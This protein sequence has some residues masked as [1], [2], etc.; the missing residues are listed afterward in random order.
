MGWNPV[1]AWYEDNVC[2]SSAGAV[3]ELEVSHQDL[4]WGTRLFYCT[5][6]TIK[7]LSQGLLG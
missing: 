3:V 7:W 4:V 6:Q 1:D 2:A 5:Y